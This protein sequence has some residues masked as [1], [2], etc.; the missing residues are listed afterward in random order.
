MGRKSRKPKFDD[1]ASS[2]FY[3]MT[4]LNTDDPIQ[5]A[6]DQKK[7][8]LSSADVEYKP[9]KLETILYRRIK[10]LFVKDT[11]L[12][13]VYLVLILSIYT[14]PKGTMVLDLSSKNVEENEA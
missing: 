6:M 9:S 3:E 14:F 2:A 10:Y 13:F 11:V 8:L 1:T 5:Q 7:K 12:S 4:S